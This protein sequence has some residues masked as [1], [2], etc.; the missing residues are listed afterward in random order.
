[1]TSH[2]CSQIISLKYLTDNLELYIKQIIY[3]IYTVYTINILYIYYTYCTYYIYTLCIYTYYAYSLLTRVS[4]LFGLGDQVYRYRL[5]MQSFVSS[6][7][8]IQKLISNKINPRLM[9]SLYVMK[10]RSL[11]L[12]HFSLVF[13]SRTS[14]IFRIA[15]PI[16][17]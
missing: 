6:M 15:L 13:T 5:L 16:K 1:M 4:V 17:S 9:M 11:F 7:M 3:S 12:I 2:K 10:T 14:L 8:S